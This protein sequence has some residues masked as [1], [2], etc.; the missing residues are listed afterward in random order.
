MENAVKH[1]ISKLPEGKGEIKLTARQDGNEM[2]FVIEETRTLKISALP[3]N[4]F[5]L[6]RFAMPFIL[7]LAANRACC[8]AGR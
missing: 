7:G 3:A 8:V 1:G 6:F 5:R 2:V 4:L